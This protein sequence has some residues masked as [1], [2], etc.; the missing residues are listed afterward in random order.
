M[1][2]FSSENTP[3]LAGYQGSDSTL[4][5]HAYLM[6]TG[7]C[8]LSGSNG[9]RGRRF[10]SRLLQPSLNSESRIYVNKSVLCPTQNYYENYIAFLLQVNDSRMFW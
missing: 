9:D 10:R 8:A 7:A 4:S 5:A 6:T 2:E 1:S 3:H